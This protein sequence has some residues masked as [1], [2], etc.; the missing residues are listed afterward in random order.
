M[1]LTWPHFFVPVSLAARWP[2][3]VV[4]GSQ[5]RDPDNQPATRCCDSQRCPAPWEDSCPRPASGQHLK[6]DGWGSRFIFPRGGQSLRRRAGSVLVRHLLQATACLTFVVNHITLT[7]YK[8]NDTWRRRGNIPALPAFTL[9]S[10]AAVRKDARL[11]LCDTGFLCRSHR[12]KI[13]AARTRPL[14]KGI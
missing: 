1:F 4:K 10:A 9:N 7:R 5:S 12:T 3:T 13:I 6:H 8:P 2:L 14:C 11:W